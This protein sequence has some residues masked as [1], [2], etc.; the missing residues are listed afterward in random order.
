MS[1][2]CAGKKTRRL[3]LMV[4]AAWSL[5][6]PVWL[7]AQHGGETGGGGGMQSEHGG[8]NS[9]QA[10]V[11]ES[12]LRRSVHSKLDCSECH[13][14]TEMGFSKLDPVETCASCHQQAFEAF[15][16][17][18][19]A[20][21]VRNEMPQAASCVACHGSH[22]VLAVDNPLSPVSRTRVTEA[23]C[24]KC[25]ASPSW[26][27]THPSIPPDV[28]ADYR[29]SFHGLSAALGDQRV[30]N[31]ASCHSY[32]EILLS[33]NPRSTT[34]ERNLAQTCA[35]CHTGAGAV[36]ATATTGVAPTFATGGVHYN[37]AITGFKIVDFVG[38]LYVM[39][40]TMTIGFMVT[41]NA[42]DLYGRFRERRARGRETRKEIKPDAPPNQ[43]QPSPPEDDATIPAD[44]A[45]S[46]SVKVPA[47]AAG[48]HRTYPRFTINERIQ[49]WALAA[50]F[51]T[52]VVT[53]F[54]L[55]FGGQFP[56][57][58]AQQGALW[59]G[60]LHRAAA[61]VFIILSVYHAGF[62]LLTRRGR[63]NLREF[64]PRIRS[65][66]D[67]ACGCAACF[68]LGPPSVA[69]WKNL[70]QMV[71]YN[72]GL[73][74]A[75]P[76]MGRFNYTEK[77][78]YF[79]LVWGSTVMIVTGLILWFE[80]PFLNRFQYWAIELAT[81]VHYYEAILAALSIIVWHFY[82]T[83]FNPDVFPL[84]KTMITGEIDR[85]EMQRNHA[86]ELET[87]EEKAEKGQNS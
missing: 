62:M 48:K 56:F 9:A 35:A 75:P 19:H 22:E 16:T 74:P 18:V 65:V 67:L 43:A 32:H 69:D 12:E 30:A 60:W 6:I 70:F 5:A 42:I 17:S 31:C 21:S 13:G 3:K 4:L 45:A 1:L 79:G 81:T 46:E 44:A 86:L 80:T 25:H 61:V 14:E 82:F 37:P 28:V 66:K 87:L 7:L 20:D 77:L 23:T 85:E 26:T 83:I 2:S 59:R 29:R 51:I 53:G 55:K 63:M 10:A 36:A 73:A 50:S 76:A 38:W 47:K 84:S 71:K 64:L 72:L 34:N 33:S 41:H 40:I 24:A 11:K 58:E 8:A 15:R 52:L 49:H 27:E 57:L 78:E 39:M 54:A 68:R